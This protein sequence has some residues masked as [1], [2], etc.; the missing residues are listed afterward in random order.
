MRSLS[1]R[2]KGMGYENACLATEGR[3]RHAFSYPIP[4]LSLER[5]R[6]GSALL[7][8][9]WA[10]QGTQRVV[11]DPPLPR[12]NPGAFLAAA[13]LIFEFLSR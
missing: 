4:F 7:G 10:L 2:K 13:S 1:K 12:G 5:E 9:P 3:S 8:V 6:I 11:L